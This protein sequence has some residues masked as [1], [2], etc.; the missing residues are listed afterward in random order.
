MTRYRLA[1]AKHRIPMP[2]RGPGVF[3]TADKAGESVSPLDPYY[4]RMIADGDLVEVKDSDPGDT[5]PKIRKPK[6][7]DPE[8][9][10]SGGDVADVLTETPDL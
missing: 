3:F 2:E 10:L 6:Q 4:S 1:D 8:Q 7:M 5:G 9:P